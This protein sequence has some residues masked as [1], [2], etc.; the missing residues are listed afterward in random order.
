MGIP[1]GA[2]PGNW[3]VPFESMSLESG[4]NL[5]ARTRLLARRVDVF[6]AQQPLARATTG[7]EIAGNGRQQGTEV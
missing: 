5:V 1:A 2:L 6:H 7:F 3:A 4:E